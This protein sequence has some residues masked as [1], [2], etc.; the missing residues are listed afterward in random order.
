MARNPNLNAADV[1]GRT[2]LHHAA[3]TSNQ[4]CVDYFSMVNE[5]APGSILINALTRGLETPLMF[6]VRGGN[7]LILAKILN[8]TANPF[9]LNGVG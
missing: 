9:L 2:P 8:I 6:A 5:S 4:A 7:L 3:I 1:T